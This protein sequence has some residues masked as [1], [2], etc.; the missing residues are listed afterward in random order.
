LEGK[1]LAVAVLIALAPALA[2]AQESSPEEEQP[3]IRVTLGAGLGYVPKYPGADD[4]RLRVLPVIGVS[5]GRFFAGGEG[6]GGGAGAALGV[7]LVRD[8]AWRLGVAL[9]PGFGQAR[10]ESDHPSLEGMG[11]LDR[12]TRLVVTGGYTWRWLG[13]TLRVAT[14]VEGEN[15]GT[16][17]FFD[18]VARYRA[19]PQ[20]TLS[21]GPGITWAD[22]DYMM[23][24]FGVTPE[25]S[26]RSTLP[27]YEAGG[28]VHALRF[29][30]NAGYRIDRAWSVGG[31]LGIARLLGDAERSP[32]TRSRDQGLAAVFAAYRF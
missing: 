10:K 27:A 9:A 31:R 24:F 11:D 29:G 21:A 18:V 20:L 1:R 13:A 4:Y 26:A 19:T 6:D 22:D 32:I 8:P 28:G 15:Q 5:Y 25:Q 17:A 3:G 16:L 12:A 30:V 2:S 14:D 7:N 23:T